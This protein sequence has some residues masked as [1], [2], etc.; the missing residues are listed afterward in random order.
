[1][2]GDA[3]QGHQRFDFAR[4]GNIEMLTTGALRIPAVLGRPGVFKYYR[5]GKVVRELRPPDEVFRTDSMATYDGAVAT[6]L[7]PPKEKGFITPATW[8]Q[9]AVGYVSGAARQDGGV[10]RGAVVVQDADEIQLIQKG[11]RRELSPGY[12]C[13]KLEAAPGRY[14]AATG[15]YGPDVD[16]G[17]PYDVVQRDIIYNSV[18]IGPPGWGR[19]GSEVSLRLDADDED[20]GVLVLDGTQLGDFLR[21]KMRERG[22]DLVDLAK[23]T[24]ILA[25]VES[26][27][28]P[29]LRVG[30]RPRR[31]WILEE[32]LDG[33]TPRPSDEQLDALSDALEVPVQDLRKLIPDELLKLDGPRKPERAAE[34]TP[35]MAEEK[36]VELKLDGLTIEVSPKDAQVIEKVRQDHAAAIEAKDSEIKALKDAASEQKA[37]LDSV[38]EELA[39][40]KKKL[41]E[42]PDKLR[43]EAQARARLDA[44][45]AQV[46]GADVKLDGKTDREVH[47]LVLHKLAKDKGTE[48]RLDGEDDVYVRAR[49]EHA[50]EGYT[51]PSASSRAAAAATGGTTPETRQDEDDN[52]AKKAREDMVKRQS[53]A[54]KN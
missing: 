31:T 29:L 45:A 21:S 14:D 12:V 9:Y 54:W 53:E 4:I 43:E 11:E 5:G 35:D 47:E 19:Q 15:A 6:D 37:R 13:M 3:P 44:K 22:L 7:H 23:A 42:L 34:R 36:K 38:E 27:E 48:L 39:G 2:S 1:M 26:E 20:S 28:K 40:A 17:E 32:I 25:P 30:P 16:S 46:L 50:M 41:E 33:F 8:K 51:P 49:F 18:G 24:G 52:P 10:L